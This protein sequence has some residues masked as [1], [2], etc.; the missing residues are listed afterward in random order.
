EIFL[1]K[2][3][4][5]VTG[6]TNLDFKKLLKESNCCSYESRLEC[7]RKAEELLVEKMPVIPLY[8]YNFD[9]EK[10]SNLEGVVLSPL[11]GGDFKSA[12]LL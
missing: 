2:S 6:W 12:R 3:D 1:P 11:G 8:S 7:L 10:K 4:M 9:Y 5:N